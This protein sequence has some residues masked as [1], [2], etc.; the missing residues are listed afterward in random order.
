[1]QRPVHHAKTTTWVVVVLALLVGGGTAGVLRISRHP[2]PVQG[3]RWHRCAADADVE[4]ST[5]CA[6]LSVPLRYDQPH[7][8]RLQLSFMRTGGPHADAGRV[9]FLLDGGPGFATSTPGSTFFDTPLG[10]RLAER[11]PVVLVDQRGTGRSGAI[12]CPELQYTTVPVAA[13]VLD[14]RVRRC[15]R[16]VG[17]D[18]DAF[19]SRAAADDLE[20]VRRAIGSP[21]VDLYGVSYG[22]LLARTFVIRHPRAVRTVVLDG[23]FPVDLP[24]LLDDLWR[25]GRRLL[26]QAC[27]W[28]RCHRD[29]VADLAAVVGAARRVPLRTTLPAG[30]SR[31]PVTVTVGPTELAAIVQAAGS[32]PVLTAEL[33]AALAAARRGDAAPLV[34]DWALARA[35]ADDPAAEYYSAGL[36]VA[37]SCSDYPLPFDPRGGLAE[38]RRQLVA[39]EARLAP[40][41]L[42]PF[43][44]AEW[45]RALGPA[46]P[47]V[48]LAWPAAGRP[49]PPFARHAR[50][51]RVPTLVL[52]GDLDTVTSAEQARRVVASLRGARLVSF[53][54][55]AH[56]LIENDAACATPVVVD[57][58]VSGGVDARTPPCARTG[59]PALDPLKRFARRTRELPELARRRGDTSSA[60]E[61]RDAA[62]LLVTLADALRHAGS[63]LRGGR[64]VLAGPCR[65]LTHLRVVDDLAVTGRF[66]VKGERLTADVATRRLRV[67]ISGT[68]RRFMLHRP[69][70]LTGRDASGH[71]IDLVGD[72]G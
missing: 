47:A 54:A 10:R 48:C 71:P 63:G 32:S 70:R 12:D 1:M 15:A 19:G 6:T 28:S 25:A 42:G 65:Q 55:G 58:I 67:H 41:A 68:L 20:A 44:A 23:S 62:A 57:F 72:L 66:C 17:P 53:A 64:T 30:S 2:A 14:A 24:P 49:G 31:P 4:P 8:R 3:L 26:R 27:G 46:G 50:W 22:T 7:G 16:H 52:Q 59:R 38:R 40:D 11:E 43:T 33:P 37:T 9:A 39:A 21:K 60:S 51:P 18:A 56:D 34:R 29:P 35:N 13:A 36:S 45:V 5:R 69:M 61:R